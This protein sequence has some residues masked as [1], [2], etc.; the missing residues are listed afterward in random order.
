[1]VVLM[2]FGLVPARNGRGE[3]IK[4]NDRAHE[5]EPPTGEKT[6]EPP[7]KSK[8]GWFGRRK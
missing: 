5:A 7:E 4:F 2:Y 6:P 1:M 3:V 8:R